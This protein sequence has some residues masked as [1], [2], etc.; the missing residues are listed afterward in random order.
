MCTQHPDS[1]SHYISTREEPKEAIEAALEFGCDE[2]MPDYEGKATPYHQNVQIVSKL[3][4]DTDLVPGKNIFITPRAPSAFQENRFRQLMVMMSIAE[5]NYNAREYSDEQAISEFVHPMTSTIRELLEAQQHMVDVNELAKKEFGVAM[6]VPRIIPLI[7]DVQGLLN[8]KVL[9]N[10]TLF[11]LKET[12]GATPQKFRAFLGKSDSALSFGHAASTLACKYAIC[13]LNELNTE[14]DTDIGVI[15]GA[16][17]LPFRGHLSLE[18]A[19][20]FLNEYRGIE[21]ITLQSALRYNHE[22]GNAKALVRLAK[23]RLPE[24]PLSYSSEEKAELVNL[25]G[26]FGARYSRTIQEL[27][28]TINRVSD[29][30]PQQRDRLMRAGSSGYSREVPDI[31][32]IVRLC[33]KDV[34]KELEAS[35]PKENLNLP[36]AIKFTGALYSIGLPPELLGTGL[37]LEDARK[38]MGED[39]Y[40]RLLSEYFPSLQADLN[41]A[42]R[43]LDLNAAA[44][45]LPLSLQKALRADIGILQDTFGLEPACEPPYRLLLEM[46]QPDLLQTGY[47][48]CLVDEEVSKLVQSTLIQLGKIR[49]ALG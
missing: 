48:G 32:G 1:V 41:F 22:K 19:D 7:E 3:M 4:E 47:N 39:V 44:R 5:A 31:S 45:F 29:L 8:A 23:D 42:F 6:E 46:L 17:T 30:L 12:L 2:Y 10:D 21:T 37:A 24:V 49:K 35:M 38:K 20:N 18:N 9:V 43:F 26:I 34:G 15:F 36:R 27:A 28:S 40:E 33:Q 11:G 25:I 14:L 16:G 13:E